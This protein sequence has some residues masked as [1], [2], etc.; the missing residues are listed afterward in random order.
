MAIYHLT[1]VMS[2][3][4]YFMLLVVIENFKLSLF[5]EYF[6]SWSGYIKACIRLPI[7]PYPLVDSDVPFIAKRRLLTSD[8]SYGMLRACRIWNSEHDQRS[9][10]WHSIASRSA[11][12]PKRSARSRALRLATECQ[13]WHL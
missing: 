10:F 11:R 4:K 8:A 3:Q 6:T 2:E 9:Q 7:T 5:T 12:G 1:F 13:N